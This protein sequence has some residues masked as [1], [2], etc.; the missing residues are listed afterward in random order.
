MCRRVRP[1]AAVC[2]GP[3]TRRGRD[4]GASPQ[5]RSA[6]RRKSASAPDDLSQTMA[7]PWG[8]PQHPMGMIDA[9]LSEGPGSSL[10]PG[11]AMA[12]DAVHL[13]DL[14]GRQHS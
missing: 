12:S 5:V 10:A 7:A 14:P 8:L 13:L 2:R 9:S 3:W 1:G 6:K 11:L 4:L